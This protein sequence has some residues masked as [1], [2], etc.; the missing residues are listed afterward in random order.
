MHVIAT[1]AALI[2]ALTSTAQTRPQ[3]LPKSLRSH[4]EDFRLIPAG[5]IAVG[6]STFGVPT[7]A[8]STRLF[9]YRTISHLV[10]SFLLCDHEV[11]NAE[12]REFVTGCAIPLPANT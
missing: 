10:D 5:T 12:Y 3:K 6:R 1:I 7:E 9:K 2:I 8:D 4:T 11:T